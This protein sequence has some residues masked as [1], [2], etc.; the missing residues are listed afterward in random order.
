[1]TLPLG[2][3]DVT[4]GD[5]WLHQGAVAPI[6]G[7]NTGRAQEAMTNFY[8]DLVKNSPGYQGAKTGVWAGLRPGIPLPVAI[9][10]A[11][12]QKIFNDAETTWDNIE[13]AL[14]AAAA[15]FA[16]KWGDITGTLNH[17]WD[18]FHGTS[19]STGKTPADVQVAAA[20][21]TTAAGNALDTAIS[22]ETQLGP[23]SAG[24][25]APSAGITNGLYIDVTT[26]DV[27]RW[28]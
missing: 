4:P 24:V 15:G 22:V 23:L 10:E 5:W 6:S 14:A 20:A 7:M 11:L 9:I 13:D 8:K 26:G 17:L 2:G 18:G 3:G 25:G 28:T 1:M 12:L 27:Y 16:D 19:G 21:V